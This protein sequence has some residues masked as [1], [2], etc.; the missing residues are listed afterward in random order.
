MNFNRNDK[1]SH[2]L[3]GGGIG[4]SNCSILIQMWVKVTMYKYNSINHRLMSPYTL[5]QILRREIVSHV[6]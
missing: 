4:L 2:F 5:R 3:C 1:A 6:F